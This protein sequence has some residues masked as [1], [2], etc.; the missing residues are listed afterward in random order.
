MF[1]TTDENIGWNGVK[2][3]SGD[4]PVID[5]YS[6]VIVVKGKNKYNT[7]AEGETKKYVGR[8]TLIK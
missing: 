6:W 8:V 1:H 3:G 7:E 5:V 4:E 2:T